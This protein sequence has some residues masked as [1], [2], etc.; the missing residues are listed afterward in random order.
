[1]S[2]ETLKPMDKFTYLSSTLARNGRMINDKGATELLR[3]VLLLASSVKRFGRGK[4]L[5][6]R[7]QV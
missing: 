4:V 2:G 7:L 6:S 5:V 3:L 1:M